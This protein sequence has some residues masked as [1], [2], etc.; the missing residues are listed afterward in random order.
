VNLGHGSGG[1]NDS[2]DSTLSF[3]SVAPIRVLLADD[4]SLFREGLRALLKTRPELQVVGEA[5]NGREAVERAVALRPDVVLMDLD[6]PVL[7]GVAATRQ[8]REQGAASKVIA[9]TTFLDDEHVF[10]ALRAGAVGYLLKDAAVDSLVD[11]IVHAASGQ[12]VLA[13]QVT[14]KVV[15]EFARLARPAPHP[16]KDALSE[17]ELQVLQELSRG[18]SN[19]DI[20]VALSLSEGTVKNHVTRI[21]EKLGVTDRVQAA[22]KAR[23]SGLV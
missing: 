18:S 12:A 1:S 8:L 7:D 21:L 5:A 2:L 16:W 3:G 13:P 15:S 10:E 17:R 23:E 20:A 4:Q 9:L 22:L 14:A 11:A 19:K 6:M